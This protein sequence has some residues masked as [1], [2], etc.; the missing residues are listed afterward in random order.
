MRFLRA[1]AE[2]R[3]E[4]RMWLLSASFRTGREQERSTVSEHRVKLVLPWARSASPNLG[5]NLCKEQLVEML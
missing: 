1:S 5:K 3:R 2:A 4:C